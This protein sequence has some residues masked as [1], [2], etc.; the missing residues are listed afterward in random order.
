MFRQQRLGLFMRTQTEMHTEGKKNGKENG[1]WRKSA[2]SGNCRRP[3]WRRFRINRHEKVKREVLQKGNVGRWDD[4]WRDIQIWKGL[5]G[6][7]KKCWNLSEWRSE[8][9]ISIFLLNLQ[10]SSALQIFKASFSWLFS[11]PSSLSVSLIATAG[12]CFQQKKKGGSENPL[13]TYSSA[14]NS[15]QRLLTATWRTKSSF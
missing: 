1:A 8:I 15:R 2:A 6:F 10:L 12:S 13:Q 9:M 5:S 14:P 4:L 3:T 11:C 7:K